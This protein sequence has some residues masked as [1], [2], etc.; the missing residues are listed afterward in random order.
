MKI[1]KDDMDNELD[2]KI[3]LD[4]FFNANTNNNNNQNEEN[5]MKNNN[6]AKNYKKNPFYSNDFKNYDTKNPKNDPS[7]KDQSKENNLNSKDLSL[8]IKN[9]QANNISNEKPPSTTIQPIP[10]NMQTKKYKNVS[11]QKVDPKFLNQNKNMSVPLKLNPTNPNQRSSITKNLVKNVKTLG[12]TNQIQNQQ[13][14]IQNQQNKTSSNSMVMSNQSINEPIKPFPT[15][16][17]QNSYLNRNSSSNRSSFNNQ[18]QPKMNNSSPQSPVRTNMNFKQN[19]PNRIA[20]G[21]PNSFSSENDFNLEYDYDELDLEFASPVISSNSPNKSISPP[22]VRK[23]SPVKMNSPRTYNQQRSSFPKRGS[24][25]SPKKVQEKFYENRDESFYGLSND[26]KACYFLYKRIEKLYDWQDDILRRPSIVNNKNVIYTLPTS[27]GK[28]LVAE[29]CLLKCIFKRKKKAL[30]VVPFISIVIEKTNAL[31]EICKN[32]SFRV[33]AYHSN[34]GVM[35]PRKSACIA[36]CTIEKASGY[37][38]ALIQEG[39]IDEL[40]IVVID[41]MHMLGDPYR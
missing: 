14:Q 6:S 22:S 1:E 29:I 10:T 18:P 3:N 15:T 38:N 11:I 27:G 36:I 17:N 32:F 26:I 19:S 41:E 12:M 28:T 31:E 5:E 39:R 40:G 2:Q 23:Y 16:R 33:D 25:K 37:V 4:F 7:F 20:V 9:A 35:P 8:P 24:S 30:F 21:S 34:V 13:N